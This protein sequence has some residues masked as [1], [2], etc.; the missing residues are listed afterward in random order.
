[1]TLGFLLP[2]DPGVR[3]KDIVVLCIRFVVRVEPCGSVNEAD[4]LCECGIGIEVEVE[5]SILLVMAAMT[6]MSSVML[7]L[8][9]APKSAPNMTLKTMKTM[10][11]MK[12]TTTMMMVQT[13]RNMT[14]VMNALVVKGV[15]VM[16]ERMKRRKMT[17]KKKRTKRRT[18]KS[19]MKRRKKRRKSVL[20]AV[21]HACCGISFPGVSNA[22]LCDCLDEDGG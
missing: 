3:G 22:C 6:M 9:N 2:F 20:L 17:K 7:S 18:K 4:N 1:L 8:S 15:D 11:T 14:E 21:L 12:R 5:K 16:R 13:K 19:K 10:K